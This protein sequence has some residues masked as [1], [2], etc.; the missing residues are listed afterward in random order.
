MMHGDRVRITNPDSGFVNEVGT[1]TAVH[2]GVDVLLDSDKNKK[3][4]GGGR[5]ELYFSKEELEVITE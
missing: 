5:F 4:R 2:Y 3:G 1:I